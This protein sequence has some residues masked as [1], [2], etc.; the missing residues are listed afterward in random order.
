MAGRPSSSVTGTLRVPPTLEGMTLAYLA[1]PGAPLKGSDE[2]ARPVVVFLHGWGSDES[3]LASLGEFLP[4]GLAWI[5][6]R[7]PERHPSF[8]YAWFQLPTLETFD[9]A[10]IA[11]AR[12]ALWE[13]LDAHVADGSPFIPVG[14]S[15][16]GLMASELLRSR[17]ERIAAAAVLSGFVSSEPRADDAALAERRPPVFWGRGALDVVIPEHA[18][19]TTA[20]F[21]PEHATLDERVYPD[22][23]HSVSQA[24]LVHLRRFLAGVVDALQR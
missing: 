20:A 13:F 9:D 19:A 8:G 11:R 24:E 18:I 4:E 7:A 16:G 2:R 12:E 15:Q 6:V 5:S 22:L 10:A 17:H 1:S 3:D 23:A 21:L 14:F